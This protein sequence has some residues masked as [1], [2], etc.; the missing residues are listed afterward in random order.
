[1]TIN[2]YLLF[3]QSNLIKE[4]IF[5]TIIQAF[6][7]YFIYIIYANQGILLYILFSNA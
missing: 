5:T 4:F 1:M 3:Y 6:I 7:L 2:I